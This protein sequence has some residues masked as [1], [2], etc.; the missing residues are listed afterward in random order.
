MGKVSGELADLTIITSDNPRYEEPQAIIEDILKGMTETTGR[1]VTI[2]D[3]REAIAY[4]L[5]QAEQ[6]DILVLAG[7]G[8]E[9]YQEIR[10]VR[11]PM[12]ERQIVREWMEG[13]VH[14]RKI[15]QHRDRNIP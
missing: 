3:R 7:K 9:N 12:D 13:K 2:C 15:C 4:A 6:G 11:Y 5:D 10:G 8:H 14:E 1:Y